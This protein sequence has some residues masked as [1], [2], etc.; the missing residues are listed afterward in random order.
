MFYFNKIQLK[1]DEFGRIWHKV[2]KQSFYFEYKSSSFDFLVGNSCGIYFAGKFSL[3]KRF[4]LTE[5][6]LT[7][8]IFF[9]LDLKLRIIIF[10]DFEQQK[11][12]TFDCHYC[13]KKYYET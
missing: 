8:V 6:N 5:N 7:Y 11:K 4:V 12:F 2:D 3:F 9:N 13:R 10:N 1:F